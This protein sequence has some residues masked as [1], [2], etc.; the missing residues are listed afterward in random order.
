IRQA[1]ESENSR[2]SLNRGLTLPSITDLNAV[3]REFLTLRTLT[4]V[5]Q[6]DAP[7]F[8]HRRHTQNNSVA[9][10]LLS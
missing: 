1:L 8:T 3:R 2:K 9:E 10:K 4:D 6:S 7:S 5:T